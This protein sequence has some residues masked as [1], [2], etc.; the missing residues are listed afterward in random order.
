[1]SHADLTGED[2][3]MLTRIAR[4]NALKAMNAAVNAALD[5]ADFVRQEVGDIADSGDDEAY[6]KILGVYV[7]LGDARR[8]LNEVTR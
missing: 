5:Y 7:D 1:M 8:K 4:E 2:R 3:A 6:R